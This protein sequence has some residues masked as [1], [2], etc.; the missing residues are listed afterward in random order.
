MIKKKFLVG[1]A[2][3]AAAV[4]ISGTAIAGSYSSFI[5]TDAKNNSFKTGTIDIENNENGF[6][7]V[8]SWDG[9]QKTKNVQ[10]TNKSRSPA[11]IRVTVFPRWVNED[12]TPFAGDTSI[13]TINYAKDTKWVDGKDGYYY[14]NMIVPTNENT[15]SIIE[16]VSAKVPDNLAARYKGKKLM[17]DIKSEAVLAGKDADGKGVYT[18]TWSISDQGI[19]GMLNKLSGI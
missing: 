16:S 1:I 13:V 4:V 19:K 10:I 5:S 17:V 7:N 18:H 15:D 2:G 8:T 6:K 9:S 3:V 12:G 11:L 14:Y